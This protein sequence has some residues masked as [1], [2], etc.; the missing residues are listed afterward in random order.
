MFIPLDYEPYYI[1]FIMSIKNNV[2]RTVD[3]RFLFIFSPQKNN[4]I[5]YIVLTEKKKKKTFRFVEIITVQEY[6]HKSGLS[7]RRKKKTIKR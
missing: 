7:A 2:S 5:L 4:I 6:E 1:I 3:Y